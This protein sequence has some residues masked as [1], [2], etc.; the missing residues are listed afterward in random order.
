MI[1]I[2]KRLL[3]ET[4]GGSGAG[5]PQDARSACGHDMFH[6]RTAIRMVH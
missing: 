4:P 3:E 5:K 1:G 6:E 2:F